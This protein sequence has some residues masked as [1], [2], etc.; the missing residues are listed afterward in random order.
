MTITGDKV[1]TLPF[2]H[3]NQPDRPN[4]VFPS[5]DAFQA[6]MDS[7]TIAVQN[8]HNAL[9]DD[10]LSIIAGVSGSEQ[11]GSATIA[12]VIGNTIYA[13][14][15][16]LKSQIQAI[17]GGA[18]PPGSVSNA[19]IQDNAV[20]LSKMADNSVG[21]AEIIDNSVTI[22]E[23]DISGKVSQVSGSTYAYRNISGSI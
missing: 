5:T 20:T 22:N 4:T 2:Y 6:A 7:A 1:I 14:M 9:C 13:Q 17:I 21:T 16:D 8:A 3:A 12:G 23:L 18:I 15:T 19:M 11:I 10:L